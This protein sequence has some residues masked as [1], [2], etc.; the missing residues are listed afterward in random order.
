MPRERDPL[1]VGRVVGDVLDPFTR[2]IGLR[3]KYRDREV[4]NGC[5]LRPSQ[6]V[7]QPRVEVGGDDLRTFFTLV[8]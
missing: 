7:N 4:N 5:E 8:I 2:T 3:V 1:I 6:V